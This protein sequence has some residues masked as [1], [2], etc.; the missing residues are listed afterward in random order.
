MTT[1]LHSAANKAI[2]SNAFAKAL[3]EELARVPVPGLTDPE[4]D[5]IAT[6]LTEDTEPLTTNLGDIFAFLTTEL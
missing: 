1:P 5:D 6:V 2:H 3:A 4:P